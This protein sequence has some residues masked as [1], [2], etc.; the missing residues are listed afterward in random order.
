MACDSGPVAGFPLTG[1][2]LTLDPSQCATDQNTTPA[3]LAQ[4]LRLAVR[5]AAKAGSP[6]LLEPLMR[7]EVAAREEH[8]GT[9]MSNLS[10]QRR[11]RIVVR[12]APLP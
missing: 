5:E 4:A 3:A 7:L 1:V 8:L 6:T 10:A 9:V 12:V 2:C 11:G